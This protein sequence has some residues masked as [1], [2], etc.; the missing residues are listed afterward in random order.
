MLIVA[1][2]SAHGRLPFTPLPYFPTQD[3]P[4]DCLTPTHVPTWICPEWRSTETMRSTPTSS[5][6]R[7]MSAAA[8]GSRRKGM[9][10]SCGCLI[11]GLG[12]G[13]GRCWMGGV[14]V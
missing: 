9:R 4:I 2:M 6:I 13:V 8:M 1:F 7:A 11:R 10:W 14:C 12:W 3:P 5:S